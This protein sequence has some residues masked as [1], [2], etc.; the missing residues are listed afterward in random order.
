[1]Q[2]KKTKHGQRDYRHTSEII[3]A[4]EEFVDW[5]KNAP[6]RKCDVCIARYLAEYFSRLDNHSEKE[7]ECYDVGPSRPKLLLRAVMCFESSDEGWVREFRSECTTLCHGVASSPS[8]FIT[9]WNIT[10]GLVRRNFVRV[11]EEAMPERVADYSLV[12]GVWLAVQVYM[13]RFIDEVYINAGM[14]D[15][16]AAATKRGIGGVFGKT[17]LLTYDITGR[18][19][20]TFSRESEPGNAKNITFIMESGDNNLGLGTGIQSCDSDPITAM[21]MIEDVTTHYDPELFVE[22]DNINLA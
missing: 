21:A 10:S 1:M 8:V 16:I 20:F 4:L 13:E 7:F 3:E 12:D 22:D 18:V 6:D 17:K 5:H 15:R 2:P 14:Y 9:P 11:M 19:M